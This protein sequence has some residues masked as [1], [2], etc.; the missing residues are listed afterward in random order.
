MWRLGVIGFFENQRNLQ[1]VTIPSWVSM[2]F[3]QT[4]D[5]AGPLSVSKG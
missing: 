4:E 1:K 2:L 5:K 3:T